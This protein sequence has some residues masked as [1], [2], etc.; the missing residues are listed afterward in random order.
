[1]LFR[2]CPGIHRPRSRPVSAAGG[3]RP[4]LVPSDPAFVGAY[5]RLRPPEGAWSLPAR[6]LCRLRPAEIALRGPARAGHSAARPAQSPAAAARL[7]FLSA[8]RAAG[9]LLDGGDQTLRKSLDLGVGQRR[10]LR[11][12]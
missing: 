2:T 6:R 12:Q 3:N 1:M 8:Q 11:L 7:T 9:R 4:G 5:A 10:F